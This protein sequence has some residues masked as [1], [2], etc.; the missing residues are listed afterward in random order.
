MNR[1]A[2]LLLLATF[3]GPGGAIASAQVEVSGVPADAPYRVAATVDRARLVIDVTLEDGRRAAAVEVHAAGRTLAEHL[4]ELRTP[5][6]ELTGNL[7]LIQ[8]LTLPGDVVAIDAALRLTVDGADGR[9]EPTDIRVTG[10]VAPLRLLLVVDAEDARARRV[11]DFLRQRGFAV[12]TTTYADVSAGEC[13][14]HDVVVA[15]S[16]LFSETRAAR[17]HIGEFPKTASPIVAV[18]LLGTRL[19]EAHG[20]AMTSGYI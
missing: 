20:L 8:R 7:R 5:T 17:R 18:G 10:R 15:D 19:I 4:G 3:A 11:G 2:T 12:D 13:D 9:V 6:G 16:K 14:A 1:A